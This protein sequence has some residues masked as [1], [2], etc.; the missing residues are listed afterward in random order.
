MHKG[1]PFLSDRGFTLLEIL[2]AIGI[3]SILAAV[4]LSDWG[5]LFSSYRLNAA[6]RQLY[7]DLQRARMR[8]VMENTT[9]KVVSSAGNSNYTLQRE[10]TV[11]ESKP[12]PS[13]IEILVDST[14]IF[15]SRGTA[16]SGRIQLCDSSTDKRTDVVVN[17]AG[18]LRICR[19]NSCSASNC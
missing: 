13:G 5:S 17:G 11:V 4:A 14:R 3:I 2:A 6:G 15:T 18:R 8:A 19:L 12:L 7:G 16:S 10:D 1:P 9:F